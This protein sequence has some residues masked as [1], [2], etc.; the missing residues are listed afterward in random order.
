[1]WVVVCEVLLR[2]GGERKK[3]TVGMGCCLGFII[4][5]FWFGCCTYYRTK[6]VALGLLFGVE[7]KK[8]EKAGIY[9]CELRLLVNAGFVLSRC[10]C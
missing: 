4:G 2:R 3:D 7:R 8:Q 5:A 10:W 9:Q 6:M 1:M